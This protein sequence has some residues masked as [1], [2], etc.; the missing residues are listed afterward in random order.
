VR[1]SILNQTASFSSE[2]RGFSDQEEAFDIDR[3][4]WKISGIGHLEEGTIWNR[5]LKKMDLIRVAGLQMN[6]PDPDSRNLDRH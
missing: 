6:R 5:C 3:N 4:S 2:E 1:P